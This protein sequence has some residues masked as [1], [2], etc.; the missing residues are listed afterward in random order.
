MMRLHR[1]YVHFSELVQLSL[2]ADAGFNERQSA[3]VQRGILI[4]L[5]SVRRISEPDHADLCSI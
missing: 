2:Y 1:I 5:R 4:Q 3:V